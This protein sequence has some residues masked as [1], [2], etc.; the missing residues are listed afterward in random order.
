M[1]ICNIGFPSVRLCGIVTGIL[2]ARKKKETHLRGE[3]GDGPP[4]L[5]VVLAGGEEERGVG[6]LLP[7]P[8]NQRHRG[9]QVALAQH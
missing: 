1:K 9:K 8:L 3:G 2:A 7:P 6:P 5:T 4:L